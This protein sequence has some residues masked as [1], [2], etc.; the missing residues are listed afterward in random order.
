MSS[1]RVG[2]PD[3]SAGKPLPN[4]LRF[5]VGGLLIIVGGGRLFSSLSTI[6]VAGVEGP[7]V[8]TDH[9][10]SPLGLV[11]YMNLAVPLLSIAAI[12]AGLGIILRKAQGYCESYCGIDILFE[13]CLI[14]GS[15]IGMTRYDW[16][17]AL[18]AA[19][20]SLV[21]SIIA[22]LFLCST[23]MP[24]VAWGRAVDRP[25][26]IDDTNW[27][28]W[29]LA[30]LR[31]GAVETPPDG[32]LG[33]AG[34]SI[35]LFLIIFV[36]GPILIGTAEPVVVVPLLVIVS[37]LGYFNF[38]RLL[39]LRRIW[40][41]RG[42]SAENELRRP[43]SRHPVL[44]LRSW[45]GVA[46]PS[47]SSFVAWRDADESVEQIL[48]K[49]LRQ[50]GPVIAVDRPRNP[51]YPGPFIFGQYIW[52]M[53]A[54]GAARFSVSHACWK[55]KVADIV[56]VAELVVWPTVDP[57]GLS[58]SADLSEELQPKQLVRWVISHLI[59]TLQPEKLVLWARPHAV[60]RYGHED[61]R[62]PEWTRFREEFG[63]LFPRPLPERLGEIRF[64]YFTAEREPIAVVPSGHY[65]VADAQK[66]ALH[67][68][69][70]AKG[71]LTP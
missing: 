40:Q 62:E 39:F 7:L 32:S 66:S 28:E 34:V 26:I 20:I 69:L 55:E 49:E 5:P 12:G 64:I 6:L 1:F 56:R 27:G 29:L 65:A 44:Y 60:D 36:G 47:Y 53:P 8:Y 33:Y 59:E 17:N 9:Q 3:S 48:T 18:T 37:A 43:G 22:A 67:A 70:R 46:A 13:T 68:L 57:E 58:N 71:Y 21:T 38:I 14:I 63:S 30:S 2:N 19:A 61:K 41:A 23:D 51:R 50:C 15:M 45:F 31:D 10:A 4:P 35:F 25:K 52:R 16:N 11:A 42:R 54:L 24:L